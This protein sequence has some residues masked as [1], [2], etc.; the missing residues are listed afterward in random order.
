[1]K[2]SK[3]LEGYI[4]AYKRIDPVDINKIK[5]VQDNF[6][7]SPYIEYINIIHSSSTFSFKSEVDRIKNRQIELDIKRYRNFII[8]KIFDKDN[9]YD[10]ETTNRDFITTLYNFFRVAKESEESIATEKLLLMAKD[11]N[12]D[13]SV[14]RSML[15]FDVSNAV[16]IVLE[17]YNSI[18]DENIEPVYE[19]EFSQLLYLYLIL[20]SAKT[21]A[22]KEYVKYSNEVIDQFMHQYY[23]AEKGE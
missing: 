22:I 5:E 13:F 15:D 23:P 2:L 16:K 14:H 17:F 3:D 19:A 21:D 12:N 4:G 11:I 20:L 7:I 1:M 6:V 9:S 8:S 18:K 10:E